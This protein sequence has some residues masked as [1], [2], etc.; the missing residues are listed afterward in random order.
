MEKFIS[1]SI[2]KGFTYTIQTVLMFIHTD[3]WM[4]GE[5]TTTRTNKTTEEIETI[6]INRFDL[7]TYRKIICFTPNLLNTKKI[8]IR[9][10]F[11]LLLVMQ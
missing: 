5:Y 10:D 7:I 9:M 1:T 3:N 6:R 2:S 8:I 11:S 4:F